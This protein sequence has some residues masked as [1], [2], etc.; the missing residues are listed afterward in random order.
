MSKRNKITDEEELQH[1]ETRGVSGERL[2]A[3]AWVHGRDVV[4]MI[5]ME[6]CSLRLWRLS[7]SDGDGGSLL[8]WMGQHM[9][10]S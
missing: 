10:I 7:R 6:W 8:R 9:C 3:I 1:G 2:I 5:D 4:Q